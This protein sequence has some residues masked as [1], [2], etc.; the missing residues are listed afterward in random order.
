MGMRRFSHGVNYQY[1]IGQGII[2]YPNA[3]DNA[4]VFAD[5][6][7]FEGTTRRGRL[8]GLYSPLHTYSSLTNGTIYTGI[9]SLAGESVMVREC[10][11]SGANRALVQIT[12]SWR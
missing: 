11:S 8:P 3:T 6:D 4:L 5:I 1:G 12:G 2:P 10:G 7:V 9:A